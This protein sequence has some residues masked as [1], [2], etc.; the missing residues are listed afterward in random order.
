[1]IRRKLYLPCK[2]G[3]IILSSRTAGCC[4]FVLNQLR[5]L[6][7]PVGGSSISFAMTPILSL[8]GLSR[9][10]SRRMRELRELTMQSRSWSVLC[11]RELQHFIFFSWNCNSLT[12][13]IFHMSMLNKILSEWHR[14]ETFIYTVCHSIRIKKNRDSCPYSMLK[15]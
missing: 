1:M 4:R 9:G 7:P 15:F 10:M 8:R 3:I 12:G 5:L 2:F 6:R 14:V 13:G 11:W